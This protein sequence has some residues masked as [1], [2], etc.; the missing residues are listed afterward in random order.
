MTQTFD[1]VSII[2]YGL[3]GYQRNC[4]NMT[5]E[6]I[7]YCRQVRTDPWVSNHT[8]KSL[9]SSFSHLHKII[10]IDIIVNFIFPFAVS[11]FIFQL[12]ILANVK[13][14]TVLFRHLHNYS[15]ML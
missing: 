6:N 8:N 2:F 10:N 1:A 5:T 11:F 3:H 12:K 14:N 4:L 15:I 9:H 13:F 7:Y